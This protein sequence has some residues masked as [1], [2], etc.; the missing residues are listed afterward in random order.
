MKKL[1]RPFFLQNTDEVAKQLLGKMMVIN[2]ENSQKTFKAIITETESYHGNDP[3]SHAGRKRTARNE[4]MFW[5]GGHL[6]IYLIYGMYF[7]LNITTQEQD[8]PAAVLIR[9]IKLLEPEEKEIIGPGRLCRDL[10][11]DKSF[12]RLDIFSSDKFG[13]YDVG[14]KPEFKSTPRIGISQ[15]KDALLRF[16]TQL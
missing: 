12:D 7:C 4:P 6:Y 2:H 16:V 5:Q 14:L 9:S 11:I 8:Y 15:N 13:V 10:E 3:A 1:P